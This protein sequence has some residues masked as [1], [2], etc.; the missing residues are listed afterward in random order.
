MMINLK[1]EVKVIKADEVFIAD[2]YRITAYNNMISFYIDGVKV[3]SYNLN[4][5]ELIAEDGMII[6]R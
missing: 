2:A 1:S 4:D 5:I 6:I 3:S